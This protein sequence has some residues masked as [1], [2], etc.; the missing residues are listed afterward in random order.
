METDTNSRNILSLEHLLKSYNVLMAFIFMLIFLVIILLIVNPNGF[1]KLF[2]NEIFITGPV[3]IFLAYLI[4]DF[5][6]YKKNPPESMFGKISYSDKPWFPYAAIMLIVAI[7]LAGFFSILAVGGVFSE[8]PPANNIPMII[9]FIIISIILI[10]YYLIYTSAVKSDKPVLQQLPKEIQYSY[11]LRSRYTI[12]FTLFLI[13]LTILYFANPWSIM[14]DYGG[15]V[16]FF[17]LFVGIILVVL[18]TIY[19]YYL[20]TPS[21]AYLFKDSPGFLAFFLKGSYIIGAL[22]L[23]AGL[24]YGALKL[25]GV[26]EQDA[27]KPETWGHIIFNLVLFCAMLGIIY[28]IAN[29]GGFLDKNP[30]YRLILNTILYIPCLLVLLVN[31]IAVRLGIIKIPGS[32]F[33]PPTPFEFK[34]LALSILLLG[35][36]FGWF[37]VAKPYLRK[38]YLKQGGQQLINQPLPIDVQTNVASYQTLTGTEKYSYQYAIS[39]WFYLDSFPPNTNSSYMKVLPILSYGEN[40]TVK[41]NAKE[42]TI[43]ITVKQKDENTPVTDYVQEKEIEINPEVV[44]KWK[45]IKENIET[46]IETVKTLPFGN[47]IDAEGHRIIY[48]QPNVLLQKWNN[49]VLNYNGGT[50]D[51]FYN[52]KLVK[53]AIEVVPYMKYDMLTVGTEN[54]VS[55]NIANLIYFK[56]PIDILTVSTLYNSLKDDNPPSIPENREKLV[57]LPNNSLLFN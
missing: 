32:S 17:S 53:S 40:P 27:S 38:K 15:P 22:A 9:N 24:I 46:A 39:F 1:N 25:M 35:G 55:G 14:T 5:I 42:N 2:G 18:L 49:I 34:M 12:I 48:K 51:V 30:Y 10:I 23:S 56:E 8:K 13:T 31:F 26:F 45:E 21:K 28:K 41:Y 47:D 54:G 43:Y 7:G 20:D 33:K 4:K 37:F 6:I 50:L 57:H 44:N 29:A 19:Q 11:H 36:Y 16:L 52:G 3:L